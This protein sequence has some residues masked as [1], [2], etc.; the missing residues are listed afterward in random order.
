MS[1]AELSRLYQLILETGKVFDQEYFVVKPAGWL[2]YHEPLE[3]NDMVE[4]CVSTMGPS[5]TDKNP[6]AWSPDQR[7][8]V[9]GARFWFRDEADRTMFVLRFS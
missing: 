7:W 6:G 1:N 4:W 5:G 9:N 8:Y 3:W 2:H